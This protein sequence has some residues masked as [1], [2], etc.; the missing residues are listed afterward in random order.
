MKGKIKKYIP[1]DS[2]ERK[3]G[4]GFIEG[5][6]GKE[7]FFHLRQ[8]RILERALVPGLEVQFKPV[9]GIDKVKQVPSDQAIQ[10]DVL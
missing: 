7:Y 6:N 1:Q 4:F 9:Q 3:G 10:V 5:E 8:S 2:R